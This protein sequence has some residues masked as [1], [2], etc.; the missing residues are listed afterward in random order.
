MNNLL[1]NYCLTYF[2]D[3]LL[4]ISNGI[5]YTLKVSV[6]S[7]CF[8]VLLSLICLPFRKTFLVGIL[9]KRFISLIR[10]TP[11]MLQLFIIYYCGIINS[12]LWAGAITFGLNSFAYVSEIFR[13]GIASIPKG[14]FEAAQT[15]QIPKFHMWK[16]IIIPQIL[17]NTFPAMINE[18]VTLLKESTLISI[19][20]AADI[21]KYADIVGSRRFI[22]FP[23]LLIAGLYYYIIVLCIEFVGEKF[24][25][26]INAQN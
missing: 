10:G 22:L 7:F 19:I 3:D 13:A 11:L 9:L 17:R 18:A 1:E 21:M 6:L 12:I 4:Y 2:F 5:L 15:L 20:G 26:R 8:G 25:K 16:S 24:Y 14:Q 23:P